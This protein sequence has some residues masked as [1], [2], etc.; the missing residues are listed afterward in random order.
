MASKH[1]EELRKKIYRTLIHRFLYCSVQ[2]IMKR[3]S[4]S[5][6]KGDARR[7][8]TSDYSNVRKKFYIQADT[9]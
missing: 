9:L 3:R 1:C 7:K 4:N 6:S 8:Y 2:R 5:S